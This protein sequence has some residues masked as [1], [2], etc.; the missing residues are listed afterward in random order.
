MF[1]VIKTWF[2]QYFSDP[3]AVV[4]FFT[5]LISLFLIVV[6]GH[7]LAPAIVAVIFAYLFNGLVSKLDRCKCPHLLSVVLAFLLFAGAILIIVLF[8]LPFQAN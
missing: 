5:L 6:L 7:M 2:R 1:E 3:E 8:L 4:L